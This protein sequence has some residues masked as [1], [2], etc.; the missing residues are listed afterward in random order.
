M[1]YISATAEKRAGSMM[2]LVMVAV[3]VCLIALLFP[4]QIKSLL[5]TLSNP[6]ATTAS[7]ELPETSR[8]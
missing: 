2:R 1:R 3:G 4:G 5:G 8:S 7:S 6:E